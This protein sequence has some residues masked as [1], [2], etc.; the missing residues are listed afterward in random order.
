[1]L[2][3]EEMVKLASS[4]GLTVDETLEDVALATAIGT[5]TAKKFGYE[6]PACWGKDRDFDL[7]YPTKDVPE[8]K[9]YPCRQC[10]I[11]ELCEVAFESGQEF[12]Q[13]VDELVE[14][15]ERT[16]TLPEMQVQRKTKAARREPRTPRA[17]ANFICPHSDAA[18]ITP[19]TEMDWAA[20]QLCNG[21][22]WTQATIQTAVDRQFP[23]DLTD[24]KGMRRNTRA[25]KGAVKKLKAIDVLEMVEGTEKKW[26]SFK[27][28]GEVNEGPANETSEVPS[29]GEQAE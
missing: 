15:G 6:L 8:G 3:K 10:L 5:A 2:N 25:A 21:E 4:M 26:E 1:M 22:I 28:K 24:E 14:G 12:G 20:Q 7:A 11:K 23:F 29:E 16:S 13:P 19:G 9:V 17:R 18:E 27:Y